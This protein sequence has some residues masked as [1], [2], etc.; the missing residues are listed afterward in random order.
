MPADDHLDGPDDDLYD[1]TPPRSI[2]AATWFRALLVLIVLAVVGAVAVPYILDAVN[3]PIKAGLAARAASPRMPSSPPRATSSSSAMSTSVD[4]PVSAE[5]DAVESTTSAVA[6]TTPTA[7]PTTITPRK[8]LAGDTTALVDKP[9]P[10]DR[11]TLSATLSDKAATPDRSTISDKP[12]MPDRS[13][14]SDKPSVP[15]RSTV[16][17]KPSAPDRSIVVDKPTTMT[18]PAAETAKPAPEAKPESKPR[19]A[20][21]QLAAA[22]ASS[23]STPSR[24]ATTGDWWVQVGAFRDEATAQKVAARLR[25]QNYP[26]P[27]PTAQKPAAAPAA[28]APAP[29]ATSGTN[30]SGTTTDLYDVLVSG[31]SLDQLNTRLAAKSLKAE[32]SGAGAVVK[33]SLPLRDAVALSKDLAVDGLKVQVRRAAASSASMPAPPDTP[34]APASAGGDTL[35]RVRVGGFA[36]R[37][38]AVSTL[39]ELEGKGY[40]PF[41]AR[42]MP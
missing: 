5:R 17:D 26:V 18:K 19:V 27:E 9:M 31:L 25:E 39:K 2:F 40:K 36:D 4:K 22:S 12:S 14:I 35:Y 41:I 30:T 24:A 33:P 10:Q 23:T 29:S 13:T 20:S 16:S 8:P 6:T 34:A 28:A 32:A 11:S 15:D 42:G 1:E 7:P 21:T 3:P 38:A 37:A